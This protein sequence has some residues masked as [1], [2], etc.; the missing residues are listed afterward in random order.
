MKN[1]FKRGFDD[2]ERNIDLV[3]EGYD[4][5]RC[6]IRLTKSM[7]TSTIDIPDDLIED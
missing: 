6:L 5:D 4:E 7:T 1:L 3:K 2:Y